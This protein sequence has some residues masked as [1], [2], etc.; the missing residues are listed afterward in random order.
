M[1]IRLYGHF[2]DVEE[3]EL[4]DW[5]DLTA[6]DHVLEPGSHC[7]ALSL[8]ARLGQ[9]PYAMLGLRDWLRLRGQR[10]DVHR[11]DDHE[12]LRLIATRLCARE[13]R[14]VVTRQ[15]RQSLGAYPRRQAPQPEPSQASPSAPSPPEEPIELAVWVEVQLLDAEGKPAIGE[16]YKVITPDGKVHE[17]KVGGAPLMFAP[18]PDGNSQISFPDLYENPLYPST[19]VN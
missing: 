13:L 16:R 18:I 14:I 17:G 9:S 11:L 1:R 2:G 7:G 19:P 8:L 4:C 12:V 6:D 15:I 5:G 3:T 10:L